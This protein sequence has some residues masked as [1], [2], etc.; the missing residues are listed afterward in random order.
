MLLRYKPGSKLATHN[1]GSLSEPDVRSSTFQSPNHLLTSTAPDPQA[2]TSHLRRSQELK[3]DGYISH[4]STPHGVCMGPA[5]IRHKR[6]RRSRPD[7]SSSRKRPRVAHNVDHQRTA[8]R[9]GNLFQPYRIHI[10][11]GVLDT[12]KKRRKKREIESR[13]YIL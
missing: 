10:P 13:T 8:R 4:H 9:V 6:A 11:H 7:T 5:G 3:R 12:R 1:M 2:C